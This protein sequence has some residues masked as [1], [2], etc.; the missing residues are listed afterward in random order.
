VKLQRTPSLRRILLTNLLVPTS[1]LAI[2]LSL[3][4]S[5]LINK[6]V[7]TAFD[8]VLDGSVRAIAERITVEDNEISVDLPQVALG[9]LQTR[10]NDSVY[11]SVSYGGAAVTGY[12]DLPLAEI[13]KQREG[14]VEHF[15]FIYKNVP[16]RVAALA[17]RT[18]GKPEPVLVEVAETVNGR[19]ATQHELLLAL[20]ALEAGIILTA[21][22]L[23]WLAVKRGLAPLVELG[24]EI[25]ERQVRTGES[26]RPLDLTGIPYEVHPPVQAINQLFGR[27]EVAI[28]VIRDFI[29]DASHQM[30]TPLASLRVHLA[31]LGRSTVHQ[32]S[33]L[34]AIAEIERSTRHLDRLMGQ[35][36]ALARAEENAIRDEG[37]QAQADLLTVA[38]DAMSL[39][40]PVA[41]T[42]NVELA[43]ETDVDHAFVRI[44][45]SVLHEILTNLIDNAISYNKAGGS[46]TVQILVDREQSAVRISDDGPGIAPEFRERIFDRFYR[47]PSADR[48][49]GS[50][51][52]LS[53]VR[54]LLQ[55]N[56]GTIEIAD[57][58]GGKGLSATVRFERPAND[59]ILDS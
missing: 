59:A 10:A 31:L 50:G 20:A 23:G 47:A 46:V 7:Q 53:I 51:L 54:T 45:P 49:P 12:Q 43:F 56:S 26:L 6:T 5:L 57:G 15:D 14:V 27:L 17:K 44:E 35:L 58:I 21:A 29:A 40:A 4:G 48:P 3:A 22:I 28:K 25:D 19:D 38:A 39:L 55:Q 18:Y 8:R 32:P 42:K 36:I 13:A 2:V 30:K 24:R 9:M 11:Y 1:V 33:D 37:R 52:G 34:E 41:A 16:V